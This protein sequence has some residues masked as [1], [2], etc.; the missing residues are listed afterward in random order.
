MMLMPGDALRLKNFAGPLLDFMGKLM[1]PEGPTKW[2]PAFKRFLRGEN[3]WDGAPLF[4]AWKTLSTGRF[5]SLAKAEELYSTVGITILGLPCMA[6]LASKLTDGEE[7]YDLVAVTPAMLG[8]SPRGGTTHYT[9]THYG[10]FLALAREVGL[11]VCPPEIIF[12]ARYSYLEQPCYGDETWREVKFL[13]EPIGRS[14]ISMTHDSCGDDA[15]LRLDT[16]D[17][18]DNYMHN[19]P[20]G[21]VDM[22]AVFLA[23]LPR[24]K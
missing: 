17:L 12:E 9:W 11:G 6:E 14:I 18:D 8:A 20:D 15:K 5:T 10:E 16:Y 2:F 7:E 22:E 4:E 23:V 21:M 19:A 24:E 3:P 1:G 13:M